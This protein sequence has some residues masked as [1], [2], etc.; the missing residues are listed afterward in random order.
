MGLEFFVNL[1]CQTS[2]ITLSLVN[3]YSMRDVISD[4]NYC[5]WAAFMRYRSYNANKI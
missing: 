2:S 3:K 1:R 4:V 5:S